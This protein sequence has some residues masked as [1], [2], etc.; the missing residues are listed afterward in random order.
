MPFQDAI[1]PWRSLSLHGIVSHS[2]LHTAIVGK[3]ADSACAQNQALRRED[4]IK[5]IKKGDTLSRMVTDKESLERY[6]GMAREQPEALFA[7]Y[8]RKLQEGSKVNEKK[9][10]SVASTLTQE[11]VHDNKQ[12]TVKKPEPMMKK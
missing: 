8:G 2:L 10:E 6:A 11:I 3:I 7:E 1:A 9:A 4:V 12:P 5:T